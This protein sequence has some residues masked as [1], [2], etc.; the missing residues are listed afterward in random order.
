MTGLQHHYLLSLGTFS[1]KLMVNK[2]ASPTQ[3]SDYKFKH[4][5]Y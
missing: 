5:Y 2:T 3:E 4:L 1:A